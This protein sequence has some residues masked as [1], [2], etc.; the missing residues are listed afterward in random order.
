MIEEYRSPSE[1]FIR[2]LFSAQEDP[3]V[4]EVRAKLIN[5][6][7]DCVDISYLESLSQTMEPRP[8][9]YQPDNPRH[10]PT[11]EYLKK[12]KIYD[13][14]NPTPAVK[15][16]QLILLDVF[17]REKLEPMLLSSMPHHQIANR[18]RKYTAI[19][20]SEQGV[21]AYAH[22]FWN[23]SLMP[24][25]LWV[26]YLKRRFG[27]SYVQGVQ[28]PRDLASKH[29]P[30]VVNISGPYGT[31][32]TAEASARIGQIAF[33]HALELE[34]EKATVET[35]MA[36]KNCM[37]TIE[38][39]DVIMRRS[40]VALRDVLRQFQRFRVKLADAKI[41]PIQQLTDGNY[42]KSGEGTDTD[43]EEDF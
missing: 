28:T 6:G 30:W 35:T 14:W 27:N 41:V 4:D 16:A 15:E 37:I 9:D 39:A 20:L 22:Y 42:S 29:M 21:L 18:L 23:R 10:R 3:D 25:S 8:D 13:M 2:F 12:H 19:A 32:N 34:H 7:L 33:K 17:L 26:D 43:N 38:K 31:F 5:L 1:F 24:Q 36:L 40:E 11:R